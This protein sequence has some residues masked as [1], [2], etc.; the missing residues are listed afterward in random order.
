MSDR[1]RQLEDVV[2]ILQA[3]QSNKPHPLLDEE[4][5]Q[6]YFFDLNANGADENVEEEIEHSDALGT[7]AIT[8]EAGMQF[9]GR[10]S[11]EVRPA[12]FGVGFF[13]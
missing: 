10:H 2:K 3:L 1:I 12:Q 9:L 5:L 4:G 7:L 8:D 13:L 6:I 11:I